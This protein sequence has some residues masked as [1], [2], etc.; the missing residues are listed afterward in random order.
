MSCPKPLRV[1]AQNIPQTLRVK[2][3]WVLWQYQYR[4]GKWTKVPQQPNG[5][6]AS[7]TDANTWSPLVR[8]LQIYRA[9]GYDGIGFVVTEEDEIVGV[10]LDH[11]RDPKSGAMEPW[12][13][14]IIDRLD[15]YTE[16]SPSGTGI[17]IFVTA[18]F[19]SSS[20]RKGG[21]EIYAKGRYFTVTGQVLNNG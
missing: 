1:R 20:N 3:R 12:A 15:S 18:H 21:V 9:G 16:L 4:E 19:R 11:C 6:N 13:H 14:D 7:T 5:R 10:D 17:R 8:V 2:D